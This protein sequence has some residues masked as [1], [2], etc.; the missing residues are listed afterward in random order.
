MAWAALQVH[1]A[2]APVSDYVRAAVQT[3]QDIH[4]EGLPGDIL[5]FLTGE[6]RCGLRCQAHTHDWR[7]M[8][9]AHS[10]PCCAAQQRPKFAAEWRTRPG[11]AAL[12][13]SALHRGCCW[14][15]CAHT[16]AQGLAL[17]R[18]L[19]KGLGEELLPAA[20]L[21]GGCWC[22]SQAICARC[23]AL[24]RVLREGQDEVSQA[25]RMVDQLP[26]FA[27]GGQPRV[28]LLALPLYAALSSSDQTRCFAT[29][30][31][32]TRKVGQAACRRASADAFCMTAAGRSHWCC[33]PVLA[34]HELHLRPAGSLS[35]PQPSACTSN[36][37]R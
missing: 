14:S 32:G 24:S 36:A 34:G 31:R 11:C 13:A 27:R 5:I 12:P 15:T 37:Q 21:F 8:R 1:Y 25:V 18:A 7:Q 17:S 16:C 35:R 28:K 20:A 23:L 4:K 3:V 22:A 30:P 29:T 19:R 10:K 26:V 6:P 9:G 33:L 2:E